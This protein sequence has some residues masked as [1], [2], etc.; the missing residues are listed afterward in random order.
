MKKGLFLLFSLL[1][2][3][4]LVAQGIEGDWNGTLEISPQMKLRLVLH[5]TKSGDGY[6]S[7]FDSPDQG[8]AGIPVATT[9][10]KDHTLYFAVPQ[11]G[12]EY[13][14]TYSEDMIVGTFKQG[15][16]QFKLDLNRGNVVA[17]GPK[18]P[19][20]PKPPF[21]YH[22]EVVTFR[23]EKA[24]IDLEGTL[25][26]PEKNFNSLVAILV[27]GSG[28]QNRDEELLGHK[29]FLVI[30]DHLTKQGI[31][32]LRYDDR[33]VGKSEGD[34]KKATSKDFSEDVEAAVKYL[35]KERKF[36]K[37]GIIGHSEGGMIAPMVAANDA[38]I[39]FIVLLAGPGTRCDELL[40]KQQELIGRANGAS[41][42]DLSDSR[43]INAEIFR[44]I[45]KH[46]EETKLNSAVKKALES[47]IIKNPA[48]IPQGQKQNEFIDKQIKDLSNPWMLYFLRF[49][50]KKYL[51][52]VKC[53]ILAVNGQKDLQVPADDNISTIKKITAKSGNKSVT[54]K[55]YP[56]L[57]HLFQTSR[58]GSP[59]E[60][61]LIEETFS[62]EVLNDMSKWINEVV[63]K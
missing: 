10:F 36:E 1:I 11:G 46:K 25:T 42:K 34:F 4:H 14:G 27:S 40:L 52:K 3:I 50:P 55:I 24:G 53:P 8:A 29:P 22:S 9:T 20:E 28:P 30:S 56:N 13:T 41:Q 31:G 54:T 49:D 62:E 63:K 19:Q 26:L 35:K 23:N 37:I 17:A 57:N 6:K 48:I 45:N 47:E 12:I 2:Y 39:G 7:T 32:V 59:A 21:L 44:L 43:K 61:P 18:R 38:E 33:G 60:Y 5:I 58:T 15:A 16:A 51:S